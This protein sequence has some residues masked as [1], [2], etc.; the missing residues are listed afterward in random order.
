MKTICQA[1]IQLA[2]LT[3]KLSINMTRT[4][5]YQLI[6]QYVI[7]LNI[8]HASKKKIIQNIKQHNGSK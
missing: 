4:D 5:N 7:M 8:N 6:I 1:C 2:L 3:T